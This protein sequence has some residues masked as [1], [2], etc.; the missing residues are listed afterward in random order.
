MGAIM[1]YG[2]R[3]ITIVSLIM[4]RVFKKQKFRLYRE[5]NS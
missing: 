5:N 3:I 2:V 4:A 1:S